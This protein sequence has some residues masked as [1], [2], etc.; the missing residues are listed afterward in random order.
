MSYMWK[1]QSSGAHVAERG[2]DP[3]LGG[4]GVAAGRV[5]LGDAGG[6]QPGLDHADRGAQARAAGAHHQ[7]VELVIGDRVGLGH[8]ISFRARP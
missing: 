8:G 7:A 4:D 2:V 5:D 1:R 3:A 6:L